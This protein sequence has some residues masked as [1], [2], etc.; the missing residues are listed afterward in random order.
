MLKPR[1]LITGRNMTAARGIEALL[2]GAPLDVQVRILTNGSSDVLA[3][4]AQV[5]DV[6]ILCCRDGELGELDHLASMPAA[7]R[8]PV[9]ICGT[10]RAADALR[11]AVRC[12]AEDMLPEIPERSEL[13]QVLDR[14]SRAMSSARA[15]PQRGMRREPGRIIT[16]LGAAGGVG[17]SLIALNLAYMSIGEE[18]QNSLLVDLDLQFS[19]LSIYLGIRPELGLP[20]AVD[21]VDALDS[22]ALSGYVARH[23]S[24]LGLMAGILAES[25]ATPELASDRFRSLLQLTTHQYAHVVVD[26]SRLL[27]PAS[28]VAVLDS[29]HV[30][31]VLQQTVGNVHNAVRLYRTLTRQ[32]GI[33]RERVVVVVNRHARRSVV[34]TADIERALVCTPPVEIGSEYDLASSSLDAGVP[35]AERDRR[36]SL[37]RALDELCVRI[38]AGQKTAEPGFFQRALPIF[39]RSES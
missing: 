5:P 20:E 18:T 3:G 17:A 1:I 4:L 38:G 30:V 19:P 15:A 11:L 21:R 34:T 22:V 29:A 8:P 27:D 9:V 16:V 37:S 26:A 2:T 36:S 31:L 7:G 33:P 35:L 28:T 23:R 39:R 6:I 10:L 25:E 13:L 24:G 14:I 12:G 32:L